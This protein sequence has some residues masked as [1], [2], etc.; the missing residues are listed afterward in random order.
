MSNVPVFVGLDYHQDSIQV[1]VLNQ[2][3]DVLLNRSRTRIGKI[4]DRIELLDGFL[5]AFLNL[6]RVIAIIRGEES[7]AQ[8]GRPA[9]DGVERRA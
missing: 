2:K 1:C 4:D 6:D 7:T 9:E 8:H 3:G 5:I